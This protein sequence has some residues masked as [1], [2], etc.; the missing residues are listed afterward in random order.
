MVEG[1][2]YK[3]GLSMQILRCLGKF[4]ADYALLEEHE[5]IY[6]LGVR[7][8]AKKVLRTSYYW[9]TIVQDTQDHVKK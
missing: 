6:R 9:L 8:L 2:L 7:A 4:E 3:R 5:G 1:T